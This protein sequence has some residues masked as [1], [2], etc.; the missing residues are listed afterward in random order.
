MGSNI[1]DL[2]DPQTRDYTLRKT[3]LDYA[4]QNKQPT[5]TLDAVL[6]AAKKY[7]DFLSKGSGA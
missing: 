3:A 7:Y 4:L 1:G 6:Q 5:D 2:Q